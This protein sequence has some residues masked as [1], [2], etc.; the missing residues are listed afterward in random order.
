MTQQ[1]DTATEVLGARGAR[2][3]LLTSPCFS[4]PDTGLGGIPERSD[5]ARVGDVNQVLRTYAKAHPGR[6]S[7]LDLHAFLCPR[8][9]YA[10]TVHGVA[11]RDP[12]GTHLSPGGAKAVWR[13]L[14]GQ[15]KDE[16]LL[17]SR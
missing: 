3:V 15:L 7:L 9:Q 8:G 14:S 13:W 5:A 6:V 12:D 1:L 11:A 17:R 10:A 4:Q 16:G 2:V